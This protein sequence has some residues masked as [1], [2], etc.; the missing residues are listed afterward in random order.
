LR[1]PWFVRPQPRPSARVRLF[2]FPYAG[3][4]AS[5]YRPW[6][7]EL[8]QSV[9]LLALQAPGREAR[10]REA[11]IS[12]V[13]EMVGQMIGG[14]LPYLDRP[15]VFFGHSMGALVAFELIRR[16]GADGLPVPRLLVVSGRRAPRIRDEDPPLHSLPDEE[17]VT[18][19]QRRY[20]GIP[21]EVMQHSELLA[22]LLPALRADIEASERYR[23]EGAEPLRCP[24]L[25]FGGAQDE[26]VPEAVL[27][28]WQEESTGS[29]S[30]RL[31]PGGHFY[32]QSA[33]AQLLE[34][35]VEALHGVATDAELQRSG[36]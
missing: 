1:S 7:A 26:Q 23:Y 9:E 5:V 2:C 28:G 3:I 31:F 6:A 16:L 17:F 4:G 19:I 32:L 36:A 21:T 11:P 22:L 20:G 18:E 34:A 15:M 25:A 35:L 12:D 33:R 10:F 13:G 14:I 24:I 27:A 29:F 8:P 30:L